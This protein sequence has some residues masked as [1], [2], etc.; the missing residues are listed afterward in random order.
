MAH[1]QPPLPNVFA[2][3]L[4]V[5]LTD[6]VLRH[7]PRDT[8]S[9]KTLSSVSRAWRLRMA[10]ELYLD[11]MIFGTHPRLGLDQFIEFIHPQQIVYHYIVELSLFDGTGERSN[12]RSDDDTNCGDDD[13]DREDLDDDDDSPPASL[14]QESLA[15]ILAHLPALR[16][17]KVTCLRW[18]CDLDAKPLVVSQPRMLEALSLSGL[19]LLE[20]EPDY[21]WRTFRAEHAFVQLCSMFSRVDHL[22]IEAMEFIRSA[23]I[24]EGELDG[25]LEEGQFMASAIREIRLPDH[26]QPQAMTIMGLFDS[27]PLFEIFKNSRLTAVNHL[28]YSLSTVQ[29][30]RAVQ[31]IIQDVAHTLESLHVDFTGWDPDGGEEEEEPPFGF[32]FGTEDDEDKPEDDMNDVDDDDEDADFYR[33]NF[34]NCVALSKVAYIFTLDDARDSANNT[35]M[36]RVLYT[37]VVTLPPSV[38]KILIVFKIVPDLLSVTRGIKT[39]KSVWKKVDSTLAQ[40]HLTEINILL[41][42]F[43]RLDALYAFSHRKNFKGKKLH[44]LLLRGA[45]ESIQN[46]LPKL[47]RKLGR[48]LEF[49]A[50]DPVDMTG[51]YIEGTPGFI[52]VGTATA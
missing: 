18:N 47:Q 31:R 23:D 14:D 52:L 39:L 37:S 15:L 21:D 26:F 32:N 51:T 29:I 4:P 19:E 13:S 49:F 30:V 35:R 41:K 48:A 44:P 2:S 10:S 36:L 6:M 46:S 5:E 7:F 9:L 3:I 38:T 24:L 17:L 8:R 42:P 20:S 12:A 11:M 40:S 33:L 25:E 34:S 22:E 16:I 1:L 45:I 43:K 50:E 28:N 27:F